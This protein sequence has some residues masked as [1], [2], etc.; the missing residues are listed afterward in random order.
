MS[1]ALDLVR[2]WSAA[3]AANDAERL[4]AM[5]APNF[6]GVGPLGFVLER[7]QWLMRFRGGLQNR[8]FTV[9]A[10]AAYDHGSAVVVVGVLDQ[11]T[12]YQG[13]DNSGRFRVSLTVVPDGDGWKLGSAHIGALQTPA[14]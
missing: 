11:Q 4:D 3:E 9:E 13:R 2:E 8:A 1:D 14:G 7:G 5:L 10:P 6:V 12:S